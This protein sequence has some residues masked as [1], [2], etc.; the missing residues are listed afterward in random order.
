MNH[1]MAFSTLKVSK[2]LNQVLQEEA[3]RQFCHTELYLVV[4]QTVQQ[5]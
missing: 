2:S 5:Q 1:F 3:G 4:E